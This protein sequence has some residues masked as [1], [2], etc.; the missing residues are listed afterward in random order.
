MREAEELC[1]RVALIH[2]G[3]I[4]T[5]GTPADLIAQQGPEATLDDVFVHFTGGQIEPGGGYRD[6]ARTRRSVRQHG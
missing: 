3:V 1:D 4:E 6:V 2:R 5:V